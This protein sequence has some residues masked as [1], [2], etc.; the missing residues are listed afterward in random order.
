MI[1]SRSRSTA[2]TYGA[3]VVWKFFDIR[4]FFT[5]FK[6]E[7]R[8]INFYCVLCGYYY[9]DHDDY[10]YSYFIISIPTCVL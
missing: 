7:T 8:L 3:K 2:L 4:T 5:L 10:Y 1:R 9:D 6:Q